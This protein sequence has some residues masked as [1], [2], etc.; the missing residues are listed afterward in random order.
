V[1]KAREQLAMLPASSI[2]KIL[3]KNG[4]DFYRI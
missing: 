1:A 4:R 2:E 3:C